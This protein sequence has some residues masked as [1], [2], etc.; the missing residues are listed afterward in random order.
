MRRILF[1]PPLAALATGCADDLSLPSPRMPDAYAADP[2][3]TSVPGRDEVLRRW[4]LRPDDPWTPYAKYT[5]ITAL[6][7]SPERIFMP[8]VESLNE[9]AWASTA[10][11]QLALE[12]LPADVLWMIDLRGAASVAFGVALSTA[13]TEPVSLVPTFNNWPESNELVP[14]DET[15]AALA[16][17]TPAVATDADAPARPVFLLDAWRLAYRDEEPPDD[18]YDNRYMLNPSDLPDA[19]VLRARGIRHVVYVVARRGPTIFEEEDLNTTFVDY[20]RAGIPVVLM[21]LD[22][23]ARLGADVDWPTVFVDDRLDVSPRATILLQPQFYTR[24]PG[25]FGGIGAFPSF[26]FG[27]RAGAP[28]GG[29]GFHGGFHGGSGGHGGFGH[30]GGGGHGGGHGGGGHGAGG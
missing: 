29:V 12:G 27:G 1:I 9:V 13:A 25:A 10:A 20:Q 16:T 7:E 28:H 24:A 19:S 30:G 23:L 11:R 6:D 26:G 21:D 15:L 8:D 3:G 14:A 22:E 4:Q 17:M 5:L 18:V 2:V